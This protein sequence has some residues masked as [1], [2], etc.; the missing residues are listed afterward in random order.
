MMKITLAQLDLNVGDIKYNSRRIID[1]IKQYGEHCDL[2]VFPELSVCGYPPE[3]L[4]FHQQFIDDCDLAIKT[5]ADYCQDL[6]VVVGFP[7]NHANEPEKRHNSAAL[8]S[9]GRIKMIYDKHK[10]PN[11]LV[12]DEKRYFTNGTHD[13]IAEITINGKKQRLGVSICEDIWQDA[14]PVVKQAKEGVDLLIN[15][16][17]SPYA[18]GKIERRIKMLQRRCRELQTPL[19]YCNLA[20][21]QD[22]L[23]FDGN[24]VVI[25]AQGQLMARLPA[26]VEDVQT[27]DLQ[28]PTII[29]LSKPQADAELYQ[30]LVTC[31]RDYF[32]NNGFS[33][34]VLGLSGGIDSALTAAIAC[35]ALGA[36]QVTGLLMPSKYSSEHSVKDAQQ[37]AKNLNMQQ[38]LIGIEQAHDSLQ[39]SLEP[40]FDD[41]YQNL[42]DENLQA[43]IR[44]IL[45]MAY[46]NNQ[47]AIL[48]CTGNKSET[49][50]GY[51]TLYGDMAGGFAI[52]KDL[53]KMQVYALCAYRNSISPV[54]PQNTIQ[55]P[56]SA[57]LR[58]DQKD[59][60]SLPD[61][62]ILDEILL[63]Y[64]H[65]HQDAEQISRQTGH[66]LD[67]VKQVLTMVDR[68]EYK[69][70][71]AA[72]GPRVTQM[73]FGKDRRMPISN[74]YRH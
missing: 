64:L 45:A 51:T 56:P 34:A 18:S 68:N 44:G 50:V 15:L 8:I 36:E 42:T 43:R 70:Q 58:P 39:S 66:Q 72:P 31:T 67:L 23:I 41:F 9:N 27:I 16:S 1:T 28:R 2:M 47:N 29:E 5:I 54:I 74:G 73:A 22:E 46:A 17:A 62:P 37:L 59:S 21:G 3:D 12:F 57:E 65:H 14:E 71:Q 40:L 11:Y 53:F 7:R 20:G 6:T 26:F 38:H 13:G 30:A 61:Y 32:R 48:L 10:L 33:Q 55:K 35:D 25:D 4:L 19:I 63:A 24:S 69:R 60:D 49:A 52:I